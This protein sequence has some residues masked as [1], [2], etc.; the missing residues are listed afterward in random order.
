MK[1]HRQVLTLAVEFDLTRIAP[2]E[3]WEWPVI[4]EGL[5]G[6]ANITV[7]AA[8]PV[9]EFEPAHPIG[10]HAI[11]ELLRKVLLIADEL[12]EEEWTPEL[13]AAIKDAKDYA[14]D[15]QFEACIAEGA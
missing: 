7:L 12:P 1:R 3:N 15:S 10:P 8:S 6:A 14:F 5:N 2:P 13:V 11:D 4:A 9:R